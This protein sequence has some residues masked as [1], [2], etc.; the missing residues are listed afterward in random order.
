MGSDVRVLAVGA[1]PDDVELGAGGTLAKHVAAGDEVAILVLGTGATART[2]STVVDLKVLQ[3]QA[4]DA[5]KTLGASVTLL[6]FPDQR[7]DSVPMLDLVKAIEAVV[8]SYQPETVYTHCRFDLN[9]D[10]QATHTAVCTASRPLPGTSV[11]SLYCFEVPSA[12]EWGT[13]RFHPIR[14]VTINEDHL[15]SKLAALEQYAGEMRAVPHPRSVAGVTA[16]ARWRG[17]TVGVNA[18]EGF[19]VVREIR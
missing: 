5:A 12:T 7:F 9:L 1:H 11:T 8:V 14:F 18:A 4:Q 2:E 15:D 17:M 16:L 6:N 3:G 19:E 10:H 13:G